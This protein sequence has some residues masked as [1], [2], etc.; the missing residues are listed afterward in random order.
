MAPAFS[1][2]IVVMLG[3]VCLWATSASPAFAQWYVTYDDGV[4][5]ASSR[6]WKTAATKLQA[7]KDEARKAGRQP[8]RSVQRQTNVFLPFL[9]DYYLGRVYLELARAEKEPEAKRGLLERANA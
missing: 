7:S 6:D 2:W 5:A 3:A 4:R 1:R 9:P 8:G